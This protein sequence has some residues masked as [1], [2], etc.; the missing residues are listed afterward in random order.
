[1]GQ[2]YPLWEHEFS[3]KSIFL[4]SSSIVTVLLTAAHCDDGDVFKRRT[5]IGGILLEH[6]LERTIANRIP[7][8]QF[9]D[10]GID[11]DYML[12]K[13][14][15]TALLDRDYRI[16]MPEDDPFT[17]TS[18][19]RAT[20]APEGN[21]TDG[22]LNTGAVPIAINRDPSVPF[23]QAPLT[24]MGFGLTDRDDFGLTDYLYESTVY[25]MTDE[26]CA[27]PY[28]IL[29]YSPDLMMCAGD[30]NGG[31]DTCH[32]DS[33]GPLVDEE[34]GI[35]VGIT[36]WGVRCGDSR[37]PGVYAQVSVVADWI[38]EEI[39][40]NS[41]YPPDM[42]DPDVTHPCSLGNVELNGPV[43][44][45]LSITFDMFPS[46]LGAIVTHYDS[47]QELLYIPYN[48]WEDPESPSSEPFTFET[49]FENLPAGI[50]HFVSRQSAKQVV[51]LAL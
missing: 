41:C 44:L 10:I 37:F 23:P 36:S 49:K 40:K 50:Y 27:E 4:S 29:R 17:S 38:A 13:L 42:C 51:R 46:E 18:K 47:Y 1:L 48:N 31:A 43:E 5:W 2:V 8:P 22:L 28:S 32:G 9:D 7:H 25:A 11:Y 30:P 39:C 14:N 15:T 21:R 3:L 33:G 12:L 24:I 26:Q 19:Q 16:I 6:G 45:T 35:V 34:S 20:S